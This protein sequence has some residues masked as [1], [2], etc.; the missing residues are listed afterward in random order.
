[1][2]PRLHHVNLKTRRLDE[3]IAWYGTT[4]GMRVQHRFAGGAWLTNDG[5][6][7]RLALLSPPNLSDDPAKIQ[8]TGL[9]HTAYEFATMDALLATYDRLKSSGILPHACLD[10]GM[11]MSMYFVDPDGNSLELQADVFGDWARS[12]AFM[13]TADFERD[14]IGTPFDPDEVLAAWKA[15]ATSSDLHRRAYEGDFKPAGSLDLRLPR[16][17]PPGR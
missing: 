1:M 2:T 4:V 14:P 6:N 5:A 11:T 15:G 12:T 8:H 10:H 16:A 13:H 17:T 9:H 3:M 7:H